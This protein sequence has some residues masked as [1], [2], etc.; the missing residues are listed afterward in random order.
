MMTDRAPTTPHK[1]T[2]KT[3][4]IIRMMAGTIILG[5]LAL[6]YWHNHHWLWL[7]AFVVFNLVQSSVTDFC[8]SEIIVRKMRG[9]NA[10]GAQT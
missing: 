4:S 8:P 6:C 5:S 2:M 10:A 9:E 3:E 1:G 7:T